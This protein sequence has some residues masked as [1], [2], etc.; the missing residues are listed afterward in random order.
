MFVVPTIS[1]GRASLGK[2]VRVSSGYTAAIAAPQKTTMIEAKWS[3]RNPQIATHVLEGNVFEMIRETMLDPAKLRGCIKNDGG[4][5]DRGVARELARKPIKKDRQSI[6]R[7]AES[8]LLSK[9]VNAVW[10][11]REYSMPTKRTCLPRQM[12]R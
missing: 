10:R 12:G 5:D 2:C 7:C 4:L 1:E 11:R 3:C 6:G 8:L 9:L